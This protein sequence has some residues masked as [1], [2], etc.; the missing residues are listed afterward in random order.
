MLAGLVLGAA[1]AFLCLP[2]FA[3]MD[4]V[5][6]VPP[7]KPS[8]AKAT[9]SPVA[10]PAS[11]ESV[12]QES[13]PPESVPGVQ[14]IADFLGFGEAAEPEGAL[15]QQTAAPAGKVPEQAPEQ[16]PELAVALKPVEYP[17]SSLS[18]ADA[19][20]YKSIFDY[21]QQGKIEA[22]DRLI[23]RLH[24]RRLMGHVLYQRYLHPTAYKSSFAELRDWLTL[25]DDHP[26]ADK[27]FK[28]LNAR[29][30]AG[31]K[32][33]VEKPASA[34]IIGM[35][36][37]PTMI[38]GK[39]YAS[40]R[41]RSGDEARAVE[42]T[43]DEIYTLAG[44]LKPSKALAMLQSG[45]GI[46]DSVE[47]DQI[48]A[49]IASSYLH[50]GLSKRAGDLASASL[51]RSGERV[52]LAGW[53]AGLAAWENGDYKKSAA[54]FESTAR[55]A[56]SSSWT[57]AAASY[58]AARAHMRA[59]NV[60]AVS[61]SL[62]TAMKHPRTFYGLI[63]TRSLGRDFDFNWKTPTFTK[64]Y[65]DLLMKTHA[66]NRAIALVAAGQVHLAEAEMIRMK[67][68]NDSMRDALLAY[69]GYAALPSLGMRLASLVSDEAGATYDSALYPTGP[70]KPEA[71]YKIDPAL[72]FA[73]TRQ[74][75]R[76]D[77]NAQS[78]SGAVGLMQVLPS[79]ASAIIEDSTL[80]NPQENL[81]VAQQYLESLLKDK[82]VRGD[83][84]MLLIAYNAGPGNLAKWK[85]QWPDVTDPLLFI[86]LIPSS[87][88][89]AYV[90]RVL[91]NF[92]I[93]R[94]RGGQ[95]TPT[96]DALATGKAAKYTM[97][98]ED[99]TD[100]SLASVR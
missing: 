88:T 75:S 85:K 20:I 48:Q 12:S 47:Y 65:Y 37:E 50:Q 28:M 56:Y 59:G 17:V 39:T 25:Y 30:P 40:P 15:P 6:P 95:P 8:A 51:K 83:M 34:E 11:P 97:V 72:I 33:K 64:E 10:V 31:F 19:K 4:G 5:V 23:E 35:H 94:L 2:A 67:P 96:L 57:T 43:R 1:L 9:V 68:E 22:A 86:E 80:T 44:D 77:P 41:K 18:D 49:K 32:G 99:D 53:I 66:G 76:F 62:E 60:R 55:S 58:W 36:R 89:R 13:A 98:D 16:A 71:G 7:R 92:W 63:A 29:V 79:T 73:I 100:Y 45:A 70:W 91:A 82:S 81:E 42:K 69:A 84:V 26:G 46:F 61:Q 21:Q 78:S 90:E 14:G 38:D 52:P 27:I 74:E 24:D 87:E 93:Y 54:S 3:R